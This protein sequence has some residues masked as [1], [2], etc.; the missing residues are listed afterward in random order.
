MGKSDTDMIIKFQVIYKK[1][2]VNKIAPVLIQ[3]C[4]KLLLS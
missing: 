1:N 2:C 3:C 4:Y